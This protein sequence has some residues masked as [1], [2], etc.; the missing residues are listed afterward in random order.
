MTFRLDASDRSY[1]VLCDDC[2]WRALALERPAARRLAAGHEERAH[3]G[4]RLA[5]NT[6]AHATRRAAL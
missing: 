3:P 4:Q 2:G 5:R 6:A 1:L